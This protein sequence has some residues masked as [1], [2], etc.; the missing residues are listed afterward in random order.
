MTVVPPQTRHLTPEAWTPRTSPEPGGTARPEPPI[1]VLVAEPDGATRDRM[2]DLLGE[3]GH[4]V[5]GTVG[6]G[7]DAVARAAA[8]RPD[9]VLVDVAL[10]GGPEGVA[11]DEIAA[12]APGV[13]VVLFCGDANVRLSD[14]EVDASAAI[15]YL[16]PP[17]PPGYLDSTV[18][19]AVK[20]GRALALARQEADEAKRQLEHRKLIERAKG[21]LMRRTGSSEQDAYS[22]LR[23]QSQDRSVPMVEVAKAV[24]ESEPGWRA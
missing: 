7:A 12:S 16:P 13:A 10:L 15:A 19:H 20:H 1:R 22:I 21:V 6:T 14:R 8:L 17:L 11:A 23:R 5:L 18:R 24:L 3:L 2:R 4:S 9:V